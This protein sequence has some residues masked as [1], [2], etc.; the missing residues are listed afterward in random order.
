[1]AVTKK[2]LLRVL[3]K[4]KIRA[5]LVENCKLEASELTDKLSKL[6]S[7]SPTSTLV[8]PTRD[9]LLEKVLFWE[10]VDVVNDCIPVKVAI[11]NNHRY[12]LDKVAPREIPLHDA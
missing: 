5:V 12:N 2:E 4:E 8:P 1:M 11:C 9:E 6:M 7:I 3:L 10:L